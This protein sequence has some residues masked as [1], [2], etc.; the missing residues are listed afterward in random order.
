MFLVELKVGEVIKSKV[1]KIIKSGII[2]DIGGGKTGFVHISEISDKYINLPSDVVKLN[3]VV[4]V[5]IIQI[6]D[7]KIRLSIKQV[8]NNRVN[9]PSEKSISRQKEFNKK[10]DLEQFKN[11]EEK[12]EYMMK[13]FKAI[14]E[15]KL[16]DLKKHMNNKHK[17]ANNR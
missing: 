9:K 17:R 4:N 3:D 10:S 14:S 16:S 1:I 2:M 8:V 7:E 6:E 15:Q 11:K 5:K 12:F 13:N